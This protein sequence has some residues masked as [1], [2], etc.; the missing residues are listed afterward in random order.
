MAR[1][2]T[3]ITWRACDLGIQPRCSVPYRARRSNTANLHGTVYRSF[4]S[5]CDCMVGS[6]RAL[7][8]AGNICPSYTD[9]RGY[10]SHRR[11]KE[12][13]RGAIKHLKFGMAHVREV[14]RNVL[15]WNV[16]GSAKQ[17]S[18]P[19]DLDHSSFRRIGEPRDWNDII[20]RSARGLSVRYADSEMHAL[21]GKGH[22]VFSGTDTRYIMSPARDMMAIRN[23][24]SLCDDPYSP[25]FC[26]WPIIG[27]SGVL[28]SSL[29]TIVCLIMQAG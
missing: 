3:S 1:S 25:S 23:I 28:N 17:C 7:T 4:T 2:Q 27:R 26:L 18:D 11:F 9:V 24:R 15:A 5:W 10:C 8:L 16:A 14:E 12:G 20:S 29:V 13:S 22:A 21:Q 6:I 19:V